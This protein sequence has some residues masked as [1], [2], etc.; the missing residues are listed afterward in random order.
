M[1]QVHAEASALWVRFYSGEL[2]IEQ[3]M[4]AGYPRPVLLHTAESA[5]PNDPPEFRDRWIADDKTVWMPES[6]G[7]K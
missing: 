5:P 4:A 2:T 1:R 6:E 7:K 3:F